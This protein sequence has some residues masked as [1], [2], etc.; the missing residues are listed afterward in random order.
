MLSGLIGGF[1]LMA[2][3]AYFSTEKPTECQKQ[4]SIYQQL[5]KLKYWNSAYYYWQKS[6]STC[7][8][9]R[10]VILNDG[11]KI[12]SGLLLKD[13]NNLTLFD[14]LM[15]IYDEKAKLSNKADYYRMKKAFAY[16]K[17]KNHSAENLNFIIQNLN[18]VQIR[19]KSD[20]PLQSLYLKFVCANSLLLKHKLEHKQFVGELLA[21]IDFV[22]TSKNKNYIQKIVAYYK[23]NEV[24]NIFEIL[25][26]LP[27]EYSKHSLG[28]FT[29]YYFLGNTFDDEKVFAEMDTFLTN[30]KNQ[31]Y[32]LAKDFTN[33]YFLAALKAFNL[34]KLPIAK[35]YAQGAILY[36]DLAGKAYKLL[37]DIYHKVALDNNSNFYKPALY[38]LAVKMYRLA[39]QKDAKIELSKEI[40]ALQNYFPSQEDLFFR[41]LKVNSSYKLG[42]WI[43]EEVILR[44]RE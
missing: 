34:N 20:F 39:E 8:A 2:Q 15:I 3:S 32:F 19:Q 12:I 42:D 16:Y 5:I 28:V 35:K 14:S 33:L 44:T 1:Q 37:G 10:R 18:D 7:H 9:N 26:N 43:Q 30:E 36:P 29:Y 25:E 27:E 22:L 21:D 41:S 11:D 38:C 31:Q 17:Y 6:Y 23:Q 13:K 40:K 24:L 4:I